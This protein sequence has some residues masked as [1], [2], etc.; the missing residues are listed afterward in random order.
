VTE[1]VLYVLGVL[2]GKPV[3][4]ISL[5]LSRWNLSCRMIGTGPWAWCNP[6][7]Q[8]SWNVHGDG[9]AEPARP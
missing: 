8:V 5:I 7:S 3:G 2:H 1:A 9:D 4:K 6:V